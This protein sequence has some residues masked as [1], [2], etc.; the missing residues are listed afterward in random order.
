MIQSMPVVRQTNPIAFISQI[1][2][3][4]ILAFGIHLIFPRFEIV[5][6]VFLAAFM[7]LIFCRIMRSIF[8]R[9]HIAGM[10]AYR[11]KQ[12]ENAISHFEASRRFF[13]THK[14]LD[15]YRFLLFGVTSPNPYR[16]IALCNAAFCY[17]QLG[18]GKKA[19]KIFEQVLLEAPDY[20]SA[21][22]S[23]TMLQSSSELSQAKSSA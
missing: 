23:L 6:C 14:K 13:I 18:Q 21:R 17:T 22:A 7:Y 12:F 20:T 4:A 2:A 11:A 8:T 5:R 1:A 16:I 3:M 15:A 10:K 19:M 9:D